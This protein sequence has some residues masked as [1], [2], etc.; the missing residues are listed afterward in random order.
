MIKRSLLALAVLFTVAALL[1]I[2]WNIPDVFAGGAKTG[3]NTETPKTAVAAKVPVPI[4]VK[5]GKVREFRLTAAEL[6]HPQTHIVTTDWGDVVVD[7]KFKLL[8]TTRINETTV[9][10]M[11]YHKT[12]AKTLVLQEE[13]TF[14]GSPYL[15]A[16]D[17]KLAKVTHYVNTNS[18]NTISMTENANGEAEWVN[19][20]D[21]GMIALLFETT[22]KVAISFRDDANTAN[23]R[24]M[25]GYDPEH[26][27]NR[28]NKN[29]TNFTGPGQQH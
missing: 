27:V 25:N 15:V 12:W 3:T 10:H 16:V 6:N 5:D 21:P 29:L 14:R 2:N 24:W 20:Y 13:E 26:A 11:V 23:G 9:R 22:N 1:V 18:G 4:I 28:E 8:V 19:G 7:T 17:D